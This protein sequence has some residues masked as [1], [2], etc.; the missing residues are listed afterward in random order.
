MARIVGGLIIGF[1]L[2]SDNFFPLEFITME[3]FAS[4]LRAIIHQLLSQAM[5]IRQCREDRF[6]MTNIKFVPANISV[7]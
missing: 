4:W 5:C 7:P 6:S 1:T 3:T 2:I